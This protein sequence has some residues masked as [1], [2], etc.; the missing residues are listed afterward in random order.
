MAILDYKHRLGW[1]R[2]F[3]VAR[4]LVDEVDRLRDELRA[5]D[6][7]FALRDNQK[8]TIIN[9][10]MESVARKNGYAPII[11]EQRKEQPPPV[12]AVSG[13]DVLAFRQSQVDE[14]ARKAAREQEKERQQ[15]FADEAREIINR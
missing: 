7:S 9:G 14:E 12:R 10:L 1:L 15:A 11:A 4:L 8:Q 5:K 13:P 2:F 6:A 3:P